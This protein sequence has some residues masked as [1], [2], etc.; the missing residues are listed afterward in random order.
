M[1]TRASYIAIL[2]VVVLLSAWHENRKFGKPKDPP[3]PI[4]GGPPGWEWDPKRLTWRRP[5]S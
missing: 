5:G 1:L 4:R 2:V 3:E